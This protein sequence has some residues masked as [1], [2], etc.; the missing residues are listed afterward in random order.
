MQPNPLAIAALSAF[1]ARKCPESSDLA[2]IA[3]K[4]APYALNDL[5]FWQRA[6]GD[7]ALCKAAISAHEL[8][9]A[10]GL[11]AFLKR[12]LDPKVLP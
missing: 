10:E 3:Y 4:A 8:G 5:A 6:E 12:H 9:G 11:I 7:P 1:F 2:E